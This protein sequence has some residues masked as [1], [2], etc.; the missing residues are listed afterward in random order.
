MWC[1][2]IVLT[3]VCSADVDVALKDLNS[4]DLT[5]RQAAYNTLL[6]V[7][8]NGSDMVQQQLLEELLKLKDQKLESFVLELMN[9]IAVSIP[10]PSNPQLRICKTGLTMRQM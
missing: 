4:S 2:T 5:I 1:A 10:A 7:A 6:N 9:A 8:Q 3:I